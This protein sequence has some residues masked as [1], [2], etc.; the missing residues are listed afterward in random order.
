MVIT[1]R[2]IASSETTLDETL[3]RKLNGS[4]DAH[5]KLLCAKANVF[6]SE[7]KTVATKHS[8]GTKINATLW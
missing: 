3:G 8:V 2:W 4:S 6:C 1:H 5:R 7:S